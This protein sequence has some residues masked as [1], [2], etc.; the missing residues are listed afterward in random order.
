[1]EIRENKH[2]I[3]HKK[4]SK[5]S[6]VSKNMPHPLCVGT[7]F[8]GTLL[9]NEK[10]ENETEK[11]ETLCDK[12]GKGKSFFV[13][14][15][16]I[17]Y[18]GIVL[19]NISFSHKIAYMQTLFECYLNKPISENFIFS[20]PY[21]WNID[22]PEESHILD[23]YE[24]NKN[25]LYYIAHHIQL[26]KWDE[27]S[28]YLNIPLNKI[29]S[30]P[31]LTEPKPKAIVSNKCIS[32]KPIP[33]D[34][35]KPQYKYSCV[36]N[37]CADIQYDVYHLYA[38]G[39]NNELIYYNVAEIPTLKTSVFMNSLFRKI[40]ENQNI[41]YIEESDDEEDFNNVAEDK[42]VDLTKNIL[43][44]CTFHYKFKKWVP[45]RVAAPN[46]RIVHISKL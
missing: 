30:N 40:K 35:N 17:Q 43:I 41:D 27:I 20:F 22:S 33:I 8:Y 34:F 36:F 5:I 21:M 44:E 12:Q 46:S 42:Y 18:K 7:L 16:I 6:I 45:I 3:Y 14:E 4:I 19:G 24:S 38:C 23:E 32:Y 39:K 2:D 29:G 28:P 11:P 31:I 25:R 10:P 1:M 37:V 26:R 9:E 15:D 13:I